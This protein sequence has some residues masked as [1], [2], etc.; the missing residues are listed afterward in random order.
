[1]DFR[2]ERK[3]NRMGRVRPGGKKISGGSDG[4][5]NFSEGD[6]KGLPQCLAKSGIETVYGNWC[7]KLS[8]ADFIVIAAEAV[9]GRLAVDYDPEDVFAKTKDYEVLSE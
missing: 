1:M 3:M 9:T 8:L 7:D 2:R 6:N 4:C 5:I